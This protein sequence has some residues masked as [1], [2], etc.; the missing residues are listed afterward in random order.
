MAASQFSQ[1]LAAT[2]ASHLNSQFALMILLASTFLGCGG[3][4]PVDRELWNTS[5][6]STTV[7]KTPSMPPTSPFSPSRVAASYH[8][9]YGTAGKHLH[10][11]L[12]ED[13]TFRCQWFDYGNR[14]CLGGE[15]R[16]EC[17]G[18]WV[19]EG[20]L[21]KINCHE[22]NG[23][24]NKLALGNLLIQSSGVVQTLVQTIDRE[25]YA[26]RPCDETCFRKSD[27]NMMRYAQRHEWPDSLNA[28]LG[29]DRL[30]A[31]DVEPLGL[32]PIDNRFIFETSTNSRLRRIILETYD[33]EAVATTHPLLGTLLHSIP[34]SRLRW[35]WNLEKCCLLATPRYDAAQHEHKT[36][37]AV[38]DHPDS[39]ETIVFMQWD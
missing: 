11:N 23:R 9:G 2:K 3:P 6:V 5:Q 20:N 14:G 19:V 27:P 30:L 37:L 16:G 22:K 13:S 35:V 38:V 31:K 36:Q 18:T 10:L 8:L 32:N 12:I 17:S 1:A 33:L 4:P 25:R 21:I 29:S 15:V 39:N 26:K 24:F 28:I 7:R 34:D